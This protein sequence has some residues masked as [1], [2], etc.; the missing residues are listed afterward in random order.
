MEALW[1]YYLPAIQQAMEWI[2]KGEIGEVK[3]VQISFG[4]SGDMNKKMRLANPDLAGG[5]LLD[6][7]IY[8]IAM[9]ELVFND[10]IDNIQAIANFSN[11]GIDSSNS[12][13]LRY[14]NGGMAQISSSFICE[15]KNDAVIYGTKGRI[16][17]PQFWMTKKAILISNDRQ[18]E[19]I[20]KTPQ[21]GYNHEAYAV[22]ELLSKEAIESS[23]IPL[24]KSKQILSIMD[25]VR[26][27]IGLK[28]PFEK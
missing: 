25:Q 8:G 16:E 5:A 14:K 17:I 9:A 18:L 12:I 26:E 11:T 22:N 28:Y 4:F 21:L 10:K 1:T 19:F 23:V 27:Q 13:Q 15:L 24:I 7:G 2:K 3:Q 6:I 20:D